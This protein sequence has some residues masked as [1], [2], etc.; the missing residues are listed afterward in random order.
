MCGALIVKNGKIVGEGFYTYDGLKHAEIQALEQAG[1]KA[2]GAIVY[3]SLEPCSHTG[4]TGPCAQALIEAGVRRVVTATT[5]PNPEVNGRGL[6]LLREAGIEVE[7]GI[8]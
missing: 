4:R 8:L 2:R 6:A 5:D 3:T 7:T 1:E